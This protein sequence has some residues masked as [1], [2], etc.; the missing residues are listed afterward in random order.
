MVSDVRAVTRPC[1][2]C[3]CWFEATGQRGHIFC[4]VASRRLN[5]H[6]GRGQPALTGLLERQRRLFSVNSWRLHITP[7]AGIV[8]VCVC[9]CVCMSAWRLLLSGSRET[10]ISGA[11]QQQASKSTLCRRGRWTL[12][13]RC[14][15]LGRFVWR[16]AGVVGDVVRALVRQTGCQSCHRR[17]FSDRQPRLQPGD[18]ELRLR[19]GFPQRHPEEGDVLWGRRV[20][21]RPAQIRGCV[22]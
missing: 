6:H 5:W 9:V 10:H 14:C 4:Y 19:Q 22:R 15:Q 11:R 7:A 12:S 2:R 17:T 3:A 13:Q 20:L 1:Q 8:C 21:H 16:G 18:S